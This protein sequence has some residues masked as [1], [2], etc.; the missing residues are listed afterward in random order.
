MRSGLRVHSG[1]S[2][3]AR[4]F[5]VYCGPNAR[6]NVAEFPTVQSV[7][8]ILAEDAA[9]RSTLD[10]TPRGSMA[11]FDLM[12]CALP[13]TEKVSPWSEQGNDMIYLVASENLDRLEELRW[14]EA[15]FPARFDHSNLV[16]K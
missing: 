1:L 14:L 9:M 2:S 13:S 10:R 16:I 4:R 11:D 6:L 12:K 7:E 15:N 3:A 5:D 8:E